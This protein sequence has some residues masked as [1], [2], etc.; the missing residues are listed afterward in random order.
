MR[1]TKGAEASGLE[2]F[3]TLVCVRMC[4][5]RV[6][7]QDKAAE[8]TVTEKRKWKRDKRINYL[9][10]HFADGENVGEPSHGSC[11][12]MCWSEYFRC[13]SGDE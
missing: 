5:E 4:A 13:G 3:H 10:I 11:S 1:G 7:M 9:F 6:F 2:A 8:M 12:G